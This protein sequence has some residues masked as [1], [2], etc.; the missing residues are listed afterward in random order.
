MGVFWPSMTP[1]MR[2]QGTAIRVPAYH[3]PMKRPEGLVVEDLEAFAAAGRQLRE[4]DPERFRKVLAYCRA[5][6]AVYDDELESDAVFA[7]RLMEIGS[8][9][10]RGSA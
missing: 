6:I 1:S 2:I 5:V 3:L 9:T 4:V 8:G 7:S 10:P